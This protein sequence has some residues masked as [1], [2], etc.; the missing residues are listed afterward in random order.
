MQSLRAAFVFCLIALVGAIRS[1]VPGPGTLQGVQAA[2]HQYRFNLM[3]WEAENLLGLRPQTRPTEGAATVGRYFS[4]ADDLRRAEASYG[5]FLA[6]ARTE[7]GLDSRA[8]GRERDVI[9]AEMARLEPP[10]RRELQARV[11]EA[12]REEGF[13]LD[14]PVVGPVVFPPV[15][16][17]FQTPPRVLIVS[18][19]SRIEMIDTAHL[20]PDIAQQDIEVLEASLARRGLSGLVERIGG[21]STYPALVAP[22]TDP[23]WALGAISHE[24]VHHYLF[25][26][27]L[28]QH[29]G[30]SVEMA[31]I[32]ET[33]A[34]IVGGELGYS[35]FR[36][37]SLPPTEEKEQRSAEA[38]TPPDS[39]PALDF[40]PFMR[41]TRLEADRLLA[42]GQVEEAE[43]YM[44]RRRQELT[45]H[46][47]YIRKLNQAYFAFHGTYAD[48]PGAVSPIADQLRLLRRAQ[49]SVGEFLRAVED[50]RSPLEFRA[51]VEA[52]ERAR[53]R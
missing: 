6:L 47:V 41:E 16:F 43:A 25:F 28:G 46:G 52:A 44:E 2:A 21:L 35:A 18:S 14:V 9:R 39:G 11:G 36:G 22:G 17:T 12:L 38:L 15:A 50:V 4:L 30:E 37:L 1:D 7:E 19:R 33:V 29:Y 27:P 49:P 31:T 24:W 13:S 48:S 40:G 45:R 10:T 5:R 53:Q 20:R 3:M 26:R 34:N 42:D 32:N 51:L 8:A 23:E